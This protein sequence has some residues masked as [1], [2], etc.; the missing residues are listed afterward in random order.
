MS[1]YPHSRDRLP[2]RDVIARATRRGRSRLTGGAP[3]LADAMRGADAIGIAAAAT[4]VHGDAIPGAGGGATGHIEDAAEAAAPVTAPSTTKSRLPLS[5]Q[6]LRLVT[7]LVLA[8]AIAATLSLG[9]AF[10]APMAISAFLAV[11]LAPLTRRLRRVG[12]PAPI[13]A[14]I[15]CVGLTAAVIGGLWAATEPATKIIASMPATIDRA[16]R[17]LQ[18]L[19][20]PVARLENTAAA[21]ERATG[22]TTP[23]PDAPVVATRPNLTH[24]LYGTTSTLIFGAAQVFA[25]LFVL[26]ASA[27]TPGAGSANAAPTERQAAVRWRLATMFREAQGECLRFMSLLAVTNAF[28]GVCVGTALGLLG[29]PNPL[30]WGVGAMIVEFVPV[31]GMLT[32][33]AVLAVVGLGTFTTLGPVVGALVAVF[34]INF[35]VMNLVA[36]LFVGKK[37]SVHPVLL[38]AAVFF[39]TWTWGLVGAFLATPL[40][41]TARV[42]VRRLGWLGELA[43]PDD[44]TDVADARSLRAVRTELVTRLRGSRIAA[45]PGVAYALGGAARKAE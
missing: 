38:V 8:A 42:L 39:W 37:M 5:P 28:Y 20:M 44:A 29:L 30:L 1:S 22:G 33:M 32:Y 35:V 14:A 2:T 13:A 45:V 31:L 21:I 10:L 19:R 34:L 26:L 9:R 41:L 4:Q 27:S 15:V 17:Q 3:D 24:V 6:A 25:M 12:V 18:G 7:W 43:A 11:L 36:P 16:S 40:V 23:P